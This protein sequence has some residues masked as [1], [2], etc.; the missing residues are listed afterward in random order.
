MLF[1]DFCYFELVLNFSIYCFQ[2][3]LVTLRT[4]ILGIGCVFSAVGSD[5]IKYGGAGSLGC[6][7]AAF[8]ASLKWRTE[9][10]TTKVNIL[11]YFTNKSVIIT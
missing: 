9:G 6:I 8:V 4:L 5:A 10:W 2:E 1:S 7:V 3:Y 11:P